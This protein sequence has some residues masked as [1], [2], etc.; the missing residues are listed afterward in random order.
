MGVLNKW[1]LSWEEQRTVC[2]GSSLGL[3][4]MLME[5]KQ[6]VWEILPA[7]GPNLPALNLRT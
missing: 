1:R 4:Y 2:L 5:A 3:K 6:S 7:A